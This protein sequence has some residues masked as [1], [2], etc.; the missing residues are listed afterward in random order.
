MGTALPRSMAISIVVKKKVKL[1]A[2]ELSDFQRGILVSMQR[3]HKIVTRP[4]G[5]QGSG[6]LLETL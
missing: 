6:A 2:I 1:L 4:N 5:N 3:A